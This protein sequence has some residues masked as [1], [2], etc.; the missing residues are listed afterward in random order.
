MK[1]IGIIAIVCGLT[2]TFAGSKFIPMVIGFLVGAAIF[3]TCF[4]IRAIVIT[5]AEAAISL[6]LAGIIL[7]G[8][9]GYYSSKFLE[10]DGIQIITFVAARVVVFILA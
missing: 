8:V 1:F 9:A 10:D 3:L 6:S 2:L 4:V 7:G 5:R